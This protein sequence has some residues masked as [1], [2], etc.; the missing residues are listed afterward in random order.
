MDQLYSFIDVVALAPVRSGFAAGDAL[1][2]FSRAMEEVIWTNGPGA[3]ALGF[4]DIE[5]AIGADNP[6]PALARRQI[7]ATP[8]YPQVG[9]NKA[10][11]IRLNGLLTTRLTRLLISEVTLPDG[12]DA[13]LVAFPAAAGRST[14]PASLP[15][16]I[17]GFGTQGQFVAMLDAAG[18]VLA[19]T[20]GFEQAGIAHDA[21]VEF[22][23]AAERAPTHVAKRRLRGSAGL[24]PAGLARVGDDPALYFLIVI[25]EAEAIATQDARDDAGDALGAQDIASEDNG[26]SEPEETAPAAAPVRFVWR[27]DAEGRF[28][29]LSDPFVDALGVDAASVIGRSFRDVA[30]ELGFDADGE[31]TG[32][33]ER[34]D[35]WSGRSVLWPLADSAL[36]VPVDLAALPIYDRDRRFEG[37]RGFGVARL[38]DAVA[39]TA[40]QPV[41][42]ANA[43]LEPEAELSEPSGALIDADE[44]GAP[45]PDEEAPASTADIQI[46]DDK[47]VRLAAHR[48]AVAERTALSTSERSAFREI[49]H[50]LKAAEVPADATVDE[51]PV[52]AAVEVEAEP[53]APSVDDVPQVQPA[54]AL[55]ASDDEPLSADEAQAPEDVA[56]TLPTTS[57]PVEQHD[58][59]AEPTPEPEPLPLAYDEA[60][61]EDLIARAAIEGGSRKRSDPFSLPASETEQPTS[62]DAEIDA[63][64][65]LDEPVS[66]ALDGAPVSPEPEPEPEPELTAIEAV[67]AQPSEELPASAIPEREPEHAEAAPVEPFVGIEPLAA[68]APIELEAEA[69]AATEPAPSEGT[70]DTTSDAHVLDASAEPDN[71]DVQPSPVAAEIELVEALPIPLIIHAGDRL[72][73]AN[74]EFFA[75]TGYDSLEAIANAGGLEALF[76]G[77]D[78]GEDGSRCQ[79]L[80]TRTGEEIPVHAHLQSV[81]WG[82]GKSLMLTLRRA[83]KRVAPAVTEI[84]DEPELPSNVTHLPFAHPARAAEPAP[85]IDPIAEELARTRA[86]LEEMRAIVDTATD[87]VILIDRQG[88]IRSISHPA[89]ALFGFDTGSVEG[90]P[91]TSLFAIESQ[92]AIKDYLHGL[93]DNGVASVLND[94]REV[95]GREAQGRFIPLFITIGRLPEDSGFCAVV[96]EITQWKRA[97]EELTQARTEAERVSSQ[98]SEFLARVSHEIRTPLNAIIGF[99]ELMMEERFGPVGNDRYRDYLRD[100]NRSGNHVLDLVNDLLDISKIEAGEQEL[101]YVAVSLNDALAEAVAIMQPQANRERVIIRSSFASRL[102]DVVADLRSVRQIALNLLSNAVRYTQAGGQVIVSTVYEPSGEVILRIRD[103]GV[104]MSSAEIDQALRPFKQLNALKRARGDGT[105]LGLPLTKAMVEANRARFVINSRP[106]DGTLIEIAF[107]S[108]RVL[109]D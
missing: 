57:A 74:R 40:E 97:E 33:L 89:E 70:S 49:G 67:A 28:A 55:E 93:T 3:A 13:L 100:I 44:T 14:L 21:L 107:P 5:A 31:I 109:A 104:G 48:Q 25:G 69:E 101:S 34:R 50:R 35:T 45:V 108:T 20:P 29:A 66:P 91:F 106:G 96:R 77:A 43:A 54:E 79:V 86:L 1:V 11:S 22:A 73:F 6:L 53:Q 42:P 26:L 23:Q 102:P 4:S 51:Q 80:R 62:A 15:R 103:T 8:G 38:A 18:A 98:K 94:G 10:V 65:F 71:D 52:E 81:P 95:I 17:S 41:A 60:D 83:E 59:P 82:G 32:L 88:Q 61:D 30:A 75:L 27:T 56:E 46:A 24:F 105:G 72:D 78:D 87:G 47:V 19:A 90:Q 36:R 16:A 39:A 64:V 76:V 99:S 63:P 2:I 85:T 9:R 37:F 7:A 84:N 58:E 92:R 68:D 12:E